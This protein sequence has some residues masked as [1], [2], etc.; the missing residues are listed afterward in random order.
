MLKRDKTISGELRKDIV[1]FVEHFNGETFTMKLKG[2]LEN[3]CTDDIEIRKKT[4]RILYEE[5]LAEKDNEIV[6]KD[7]ELATKDREI[8]AKDDKI[9]AQDN[10]INDLKNKINQLRSLDDLNSPKAK[11]ILNVLINL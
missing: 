3:M 1:D 7:S 9:K 10:T 11:Y 6:A 5:D 2:E 4:M 8:A